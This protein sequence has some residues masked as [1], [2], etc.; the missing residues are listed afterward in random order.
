MLLPVVVNSSRAALFFAVEVLHLLKGAVG[1]EF[2]SMVLYEVQ[3]SK[4][5]GDGVKVGD[6]SDGREGESERAAFLVVPL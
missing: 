1:G 6:V 2:N 4:Q 5:G 3:V